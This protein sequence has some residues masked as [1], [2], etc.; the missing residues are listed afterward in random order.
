MKSGLS[1]CVPQKW[2]FFTTAAQNKQIRTT[3][4]DFKWIWNAFSPMLA[5]ITLGHFNNIYDGPPLAKHPLAKHF[6]KMQGKGTTTLQTR[7]A[8][9]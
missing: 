1:I 8:Q 7:S 6:L 5:S 9:D 2:M 3:F 4:E